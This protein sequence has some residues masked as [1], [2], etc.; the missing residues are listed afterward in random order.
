[1]ITRR[2]FHK[3]K[4]KPVF[5]DGIR[6]ASKLEHRFYRHVELQK[7]I[8]MIVFFLRQVP[9]HLPGGV[10]YVCDFQIFYASGDVRFIDV[11]GVETVEF[12]MKKKLVE[13]TYPVTIEVI[14]KGD[15]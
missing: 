10:R 9:F 12:I 4:A 5:E 3:F 14:K 13:A 15:F 2:H 7:K 6:F 1:M 11:K 8:G